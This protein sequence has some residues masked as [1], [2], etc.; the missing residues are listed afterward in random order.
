MANKNEKNQKKN[1]TQLSLEYFSNVPVSEIFRIILS[2]IESQIVT[3]EKPHRLDST[4][5]HHLLEML[6]FLK[7]L[8][9]FYQNILPEGEYKKLLIL[10]N[11]F[12]KH[13]FD[14]ARDNKLYCN[15][16]KTDDPFALYDII[17]LVDKYKVINTERLELRKILLDLKEES[18]KTSL[19]D[20]SLN[21][22][23]SKE[24]MESEEFLPFTLLDQALLAYHQLLKLDRFFEKHYKSKVLSNP[25]LVFLNTIGSTI[26]ESEVKKALI[27]FQIAFSEKALDQQNFEDFKTNIQKLAS[28]AKIFSQTKERDVLT[29]WSQKP[30]PRKNAS[31]EFQLFMHHLLTVYPNGYNVVSMQRTLQDELFS[32]K[33]LCPTKP[34]QKKFRT[35]TEKQKQKDSLEQ[36]IKSGIKKYNLSLVDNAFSSD[37]LLGCNFETASEKAQIMF[38]QKQQILDKQSALFLKKDMEYLELSDYNFLDSLF[39]LETL[40]IKEKKKKFELWKQQEPLIFTDFQIFSKSISPVKT[41]DNYSILNNSVFLNIKFSPLFLDKRHTIINTY[42]SSGFTKNI[43]QKNGNVMSMFGVLVHII[44][45]FKDLLKLSPYQTTQKVGLARKYQI[46]Q[47]FLETGHLI[48]KPSLFFELFEDSLGFFGVKFEK[49][50]I[51]LEKKVFRPL[52]ANQIDLEMLRYLEAVVPTLKPICEE[53][54]SPQYVIVPSFVGLAIFP[55]RD[56]IDFLVKRLPFNFPLPGQFSFQVFDK[57]NLPNGVDREW[58]FFHSVIQ[59]VFNELV[60]NSKSPVWAKLQTQKN[61]QDLNLI[62]PVTNKTGLSQFF[63]L[64][65]NNSKDDFTLSVRISFLLVWQEN[66]KRF[67]KVLER[68]SQNSQF[69][70]TELKKVK[71]ELRVLQ[72]KLETRN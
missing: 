34:L 42:F 58:L 25:D 4:L 33:L 19:N 18:V 67:Q 41:F 2:K 51:D 38:L 52:E 48:P 56:M 23:S 16:I 20:S 30:V 69:L 45:S 24:S 31:R 28:G 70:S 37:L 1:E 57:L 43:F 13:A 26:Q 53:K 39:A 27:E 49:F 12:S 32:K 60:S 46:T 17:H 35:K 22:S 47:T 21:L 36:K 9:F 15:A 11:K 64:N 10:F 68:N 59:K 62:L 55:R 65:Q 50:Q 72:E 6:I 29:S 63:P 61:Y 3:I 66:L 7:T 71:L 5:S 54:T 40:L 8:L 44:K 14:Y